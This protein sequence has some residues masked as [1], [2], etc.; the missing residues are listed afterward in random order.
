MISNLIQ[1]VNGVINS[2]YKEIDVKD[3]PTQGYFYQDDFKVLIK[4]ASFEDALEYNFNFLKDKKG[5]PNLGVVLYEIYK[6]IKN[7]TNFGNYKFEDL[8][9]NDVLYLFF[10]IVKFTMNK[11]IYIPYYNDLINQEFYIKFNKENFNYFDYNS[12]GYDY[13]KETKEFIASGY[14]LSMHSIGI[15]N[16]LVDYIYQKEI[17]GKK[18]MLNYDFLFFIGNKNYL[19][20]GEMDNLVTIFNED[21]DK[22]ELDITRNLVDKIAM[23]IPCTVKL[24]NEIVGVDLYTTDF[25][26]M[27]M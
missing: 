1:V 15:Q 22:K 18:T 21:L 23:S 12:L 4:K 2:N 19:S 25:E 24:G 10:E 13:D 8:K 14:R 11:E 20:D 26:H 7:N 6:I 16:C 5:R 3:L 17:S 27:F 9:S